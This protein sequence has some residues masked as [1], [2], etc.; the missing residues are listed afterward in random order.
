[1]IPEDFY[2]IPEDIEEIEAD[3]AKPLD[4]QLKDLDRL[5]SPDNEFTNFFNPGF[6]LHL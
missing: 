6:N 3:A 1:M 4:E 5:L 2:T